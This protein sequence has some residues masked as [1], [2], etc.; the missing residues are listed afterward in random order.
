[1]V[2]GRRCEAGQEAGGR[3]VDQ[4]TSRRPGG[5]VRRG[6]SNRTAAL[7][8][9]QK[10]ARRRQRQRLEW[11]GERARAAPCYDGKVAPAAAGA[12]SGRAAEREV[13]RQRAQTPARP[14]KR[15]REAG[16][17]RH[18]C[19]AARS[20]SSGPVC[21]QR[22]CPIGLGISE[23]RVLY[24]AIAMSQTLRWCACVLARSRARAVRPLPLCCGARCSPARCVAAASIHPHTRACG[25]RSAESGL[26]RCCQR[27]PRHARS[28]A[29]AAA[30]ALSG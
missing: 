8:K 28:S 11:R 24:F 2:P 3:A 21:R 16:T 15:R 22:E 26:W 9:A 23:A 18:A 4:V 19:A 7:S 29:A 10:Q 1:M 14:A 5:G 25:P 27:P 12:R 6:W 30:A 13:E 17:A 20:R